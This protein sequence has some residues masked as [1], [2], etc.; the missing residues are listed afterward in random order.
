MKV[1]KRLIALAA[2]AALLALGACA[3]PFRADVSRFQALPAPQGQSFVIQAEDPEMQGGLEFSHYA[4]LVSQRLVE[5][6]YQPAASPEQATLVVTL[7]YGV[8]N[9]RERIVS[10]P[11][12]FGY[13]HFGFH[14]PWYGRYGQLEDPFGVRWSIGAP[15]KA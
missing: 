7:D 9:G 11:D 12:P 6:G 5:Q 15:T 1:S 14:R 4:A 13:G 8:D 3:T 2:P 10:R